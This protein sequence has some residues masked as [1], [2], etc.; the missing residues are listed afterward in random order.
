[1]HSFLLPGQEAYRDIDA[2]HEIRIRAHPAQQII[3]QL[4]YTKGTDGMFVDPGGRKLSVELRT[5]NRVGVQLSGRS[6]IRTI[7]SKSG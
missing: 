7:G 3:Q 4:G 5:T 2:S 1:M 6:T